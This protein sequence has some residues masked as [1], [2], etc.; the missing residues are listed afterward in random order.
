[1]YRIADRATLQDVD[2][3]SIH[4]RD[5]DVTPERLLRAVD[6]ADRTWSV[7]EGAFC[8]AIA[9]LQGNNFWV[10]TTTETDRRPK[11]VIKAQR[12]ILKSLPEG[13]A[14]YSIFPADDNRVQLLAKAGGFVPTEV[15]NNYKNTGR[16]HQVV[17]RT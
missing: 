14:V 11:A 3:V 6:A 13:L 1:M 7:R 4:A 16:P 5:A 12:E 8:V 2:D 17:W 10:V 9:G 15:I